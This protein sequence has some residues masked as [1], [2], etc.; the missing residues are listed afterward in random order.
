VLYYD[1]IPFVFVGYAKLIEELFC[2][3]ADNLR[4]ILA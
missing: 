4:E 3:L 1:E 2:R